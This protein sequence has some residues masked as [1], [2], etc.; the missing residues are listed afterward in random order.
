MASENNSSTLRAAK[1]YGDYLAMLIVPCVLSI[2]FYGTAAVRTLCAGLITAVVCDFTASYI[3]KRRYFAA[4][5]S[6]SK[7]SFCPAEPRFQNFKK[8]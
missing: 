7:K 3:V 2:W 1:I 6:V 4:D 5:L 8:F